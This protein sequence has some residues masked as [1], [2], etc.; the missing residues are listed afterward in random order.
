MSAEAVAQMIGERTQPLRAFEMS[1]LAGDRVDELQ[2][3]R[4]QLQWPLV[5]VGV[6]RQE[7]RIDAIS[8]D[9]QVFFRLDAE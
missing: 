9:R 1:H 8:D 4:E 6:R 2:G 5:V 7:V 3:A